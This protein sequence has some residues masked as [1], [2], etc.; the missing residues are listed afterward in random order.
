[1]CFYFRRQS[2]DPCFPLTSNGINGSSTSISAPSL[3]QQNQPQES[4]PD[5]NVTLT[6]ETFSGMRQAIA[7]SM[8]IDGDHA[9]IQTTRPQFYIDNFPQVSLPQPQIQ[10]GARH[11]FTVE[12]AKD[13][14]FY[15]NGTSFNSGATYPTF[16]NN[17]PAMSKSQSFPY[18]AQPAYPNN[19]MN[20]YNGQ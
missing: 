5:Y 11:I 19:S 8:E 2:A 9:G 4:D 18:F 6:A 7:Q 16:E 10:V 12:T 15:T 13:L 3:D 17:I 14:C 20:D 1:M